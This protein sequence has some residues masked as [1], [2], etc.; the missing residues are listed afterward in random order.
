[1][2]YHDQSGLEADAVVVLRDGRWG[3][4]EVKLGDGMVNDGAESLLAVARK[5]DNVEM[6]P[7]SFLAVITPSGY[8]YRRPDGVDVVPITCLRP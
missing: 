4:V 8:A 5:V 1:M 2:R 3:A 6:G 7:P